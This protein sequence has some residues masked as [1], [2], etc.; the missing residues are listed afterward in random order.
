MGL[1]SSKG[2]PKE[3]TVNRIEVAIT[4]DALLNLQSQT[5]ETKKPAATE[6]ASDT[7]LHHEDQLRLNSEINQR[8]NDYEKRL[9]DSFNN[10]SKE[11]EDLFRTRYKT[12]PICVDLQTT[13]MDC[14][15][16]NSKYPLK[17]LDVSNQY[18]KCVEEERQNRFNLTK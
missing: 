13:V 17:C 5:T 11:V 12:M 14:L 3:I 8:L 9:I 10:A 15:N 7:K 1:W 4:E 16:S 6:V 2:Q 18:L